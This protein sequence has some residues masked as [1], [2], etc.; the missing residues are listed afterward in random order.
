M[1]CMLLESTPCMLLRTTTP[2]KPQPHPRHAC[3]WRPQHA[4]S[5]ALTPCMPLDTTRTVAAW[6]G[7]PHNTTPHSPAPSWRAEPLLE[8][9]HASAAGL[10]LLRGHCPSGALV[11]A[12]GIQMQ[13]MMVMLWRVMVG[14]RRAMPLRGPMQHPCCAPMRH[15]NARREGRGRGHLVGDGE[16]AFG[17]K[18][19][20]LQ[21]TGPPTGSMRQ[22]HA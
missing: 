14:M 11:L 1:A 2:Y 7:T 19:Q 16:A 10:Q 20:G 4:E 15:W 18:M 5:T 22:A 6:H 9:R 8:A 12:Q 3:F 17:Q 21:K 13:A